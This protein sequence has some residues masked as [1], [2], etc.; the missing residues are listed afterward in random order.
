[1]TGTGGKEI[2]ALPP[3]GRVL[4]VFFYSSFY[5]LFIY[6]STCIFYLYIFIYIF[7]PFIYLFFYYFRLALILAK[8]FSASSLLFARASLDKFEFRAQSS[9]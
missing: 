9:S 8:Q 3:P 1:M 4:F 7:H 2:V 5:D 6:L